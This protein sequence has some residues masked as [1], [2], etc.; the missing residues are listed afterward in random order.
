[1]DLKAEDTPNE[2]SS[3]SSSNTSNLTSSTLIRDLQKI[4]LNPN[5]LT[6]VQV[7]AKILMRVREDKDQRDMEEAQ[8]LELE[9]LHRKP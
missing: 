6:P 3:K 9:N 8:R 4:M 5:S 2:S 7:L 1:V